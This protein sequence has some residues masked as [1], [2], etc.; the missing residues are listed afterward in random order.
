MIAVPPPSSSAV[1]CMCS[2]TSWSSCAPCSPTAPQ[3][4][5][6][7]TSCSL[8]DILSLRG[9]SPS[10]TNS[11]RII[12]QSSSSLRSSSATLLMFSEPDHRTFSVLHT[13]PKSQDCP[14]VPSHSCQLTWDSDV[15]WLLLCSRHCLSA[16]CWPAKLM[17]YYGVTTAAFTSWQTVLWDSLLASS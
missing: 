2:P 9:S 8:A 11:N 7:T 3:S 13:S 14:S 12:P 15:L 4:I 16:W 10:H 1:P 5:T 6:S 17:T